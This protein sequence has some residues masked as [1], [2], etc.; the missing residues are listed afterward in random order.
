MGNGG[1]FDQTDID[2]YFT[3]KKD[4][5]DARQNNKKEG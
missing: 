2:R 3:N 1:H 5:D 4:E